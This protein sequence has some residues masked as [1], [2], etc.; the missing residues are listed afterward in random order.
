M[1]IIIYIHVDYIYIY[2][3]YCSHVTLDSKISHLA[4]KNLV[5]GL[6]LNDHYSAILYR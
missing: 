3:K 4:N 6:H 1:I 5:K 2:S